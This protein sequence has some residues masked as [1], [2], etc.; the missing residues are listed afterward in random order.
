[1][2]LSPFAPDRMSR[3]PESVQQVAEVIGESAALDLVRRWPRTR[4]KGD[5]P[6]RPVLY[7]P[8]RLPERHRLIDIIGADKA[9]ELVRVFAG[10]TIFLATCASVVRN[11]RDTAILEAMR[12]QPTMTPAAVSAKFGI[13]PEHAR[14]IMRRLRSS[15]PAMGTGEARRDHHD[16]IPKAHAA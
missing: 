1:M 5:V 9:R 3:L 16:S 6:F 8:A 14:K 15:I 7:V 12:G 11:D 13:H 10:E 4:T 2:G